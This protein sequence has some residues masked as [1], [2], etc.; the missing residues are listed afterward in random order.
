MVN[1]SNVDH[2]EYSERKDSVDNGVQISGVTHLRINKNECKFPINSTMKFSILA[3][4]NAFTSKMGWYKIF[5]K[6]L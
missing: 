5:R 3:Q 1:H 6:I 4:S 2:L